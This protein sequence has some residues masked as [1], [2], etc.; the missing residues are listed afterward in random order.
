MKK[1]LLVDDDPMFCEAIQD[2]L[3]S[4][5]SCDVTVAE[6]GSRAYEHI[7]CNRFNLILLDLKMP[8]MDGIETIKAIREWQRDVPIIVMSGDNNQVAI[9]EA[10]DTGANEFLQKPFRMDT[11]LDRIAVN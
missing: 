4:F 6:N 5:A 3:V 1:I 7:R 2:F 11:L 8:K 9:R 10:I